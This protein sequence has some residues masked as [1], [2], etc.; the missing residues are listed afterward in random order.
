MKHLLLTGGLLVTSFAARS[1]AAPP[2]TYEFLTVIEVESP[3]LKLAR[4]AFAP[5]FQ[6]L[7]EI[8]LERLPG[9]VSDDYTPT[10]TRN[11]EVVNRQLGALTAAGWELVH[12]SSAGVALSP[13]VDERQY[14]FRR[15]KK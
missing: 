5:A 7:T 3:F 1:Q 14:L 8:K 9:S 12:V 4:L 10:Y 15:L 13:A 6:G 2:L 11:L